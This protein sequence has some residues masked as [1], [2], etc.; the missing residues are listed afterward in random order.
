MK[1]LHEESHLAAPR[2]NFPSNTQHWTGNDAFHTMRTEEN[3]PIFTAAITNFIQKKKGQVV[4]AEREQCSRKNFTTVRRNSLVHYKKRKDTFPM[5]RPKVCVTE[6][7]NRGRVITN[8][9]TLTATGCIVFAHVTATHTYRPHRPTSCKQEITSEIISSLRI[10]TQN[11]CTLNVE[12]KITGA[13]NYV[14]SMS[15]TVCHCEGR[16]GIGIWLYQRMPLPTQTA[17]E[18]SQLPFNCVHEVEIV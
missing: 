16:V 17:P 12:G 3:T 18:S 9:H 5:L 7:K 14:H 8:R 1:L 11:H 15:T 10:D 2:Y 6:V 13:G 4:M